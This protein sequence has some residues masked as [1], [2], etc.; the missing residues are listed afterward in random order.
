MSYPLAHVVSRWDAT[1]ASILTQFDAVLANAMS[2]SEPVLATIRDTV[3]PLER[4]WSPVQAQLHRTTDQVSEAWDAA[5]DELSEV[6]GLPEGAMWA[7]G[8]KRDAASTELEV[9]HGRARAA[10]FARAALAMHEAA[11]R[12]G[13]PGQLR[14]VAATGGVLL[15]EHAAIENWAAMK[16]AQTQIHAYRDK[17]AVPLE[18]L[19]YYEAVA[20]NYWRVRVSVEAEH[21]PAQ[22]SYVDTR[23]Q[24]L[25]TQTRK[26]LRGFPQYRESM[27]RA[28]P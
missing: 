9:R 23:L 7:E 24:G 11:Q 18:L 2:A 5:S 4:I 12:S 3:A 19:A 10:T 1:L 21:E 14:V 25:A 16:V 15:A 26:F 6:D 13:D 17:R 28:T 20:T 22:R 27:A 8:C